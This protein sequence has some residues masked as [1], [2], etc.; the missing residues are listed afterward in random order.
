M[1]DRSETDGTGLVLVTAATGYIGSHI[2]EPLARAGF[3]VRVAARTPARLSTAVRRSAAQVVAADALDPAAVAESLAG[4]DV[5]YYLVH[6]LGAGADYAQR[7]RSAAEI[8]AAAAREAGVSRIVYLGGLGGDA[9][10]LSEHLASRHEVGTAL[11]GAG[12]PVIEF[13]ASIV[14]GSGSTS[15]EM[16]RNLTEKI[17]VM[18]T[19]RWVRMAAQPVAVADVVSYLVDAATVLIAEGVTHQ[20]YE[21]GGSEIVSYGDLLRLYA[22]ERGLKRLVI[23]IPLLSPGLSGWWLYLFT[24]KEATVG[25]QLAESLKFPTVVTDHAAARDF[26]HIEPVGATEAM[27]RAFLDE[28]QAFSEILWDTEFAGRTQ[29]VHALR[30][31]RYIDSRV[32]HTECPPEAAFDPIACIGAENGWYAF[33]TLWDIRGFVDMVLGGPGRR[34]GRRDQYALLEGDYL[35]WWRVERVVAPLLLRLHAE[36]KVPGEGWLQ[37][38]LSP[39]LDGTFVRQTAVFDAKGIW[40]RL[41]W[42]AVLP[43]HHFVFNGTLEG[44]RREC[45]ALMTGPTTCP[46]PGEWQRSSDKRKTESADGV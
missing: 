7:D 37:Y 31:G 43:F 18:T 45:T 19:P 13:R 25:R 8:F 42:Y 35:E 26:P 38:E 30:E 6:T 2:V 40:G 44:I 11:A 1:V 14:I 28:D 23:P 17:P 24:P 22:G 3:S 21:I 4:V 10:E 27:R 12:V 16:I 9:G 34:R 33:D 15:F 36:M 32:I 46:L 29:P 5:A 41:Y 39:D 20:I